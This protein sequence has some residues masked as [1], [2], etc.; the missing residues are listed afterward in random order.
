[1][2]S[3]PLEDPSDPEANKWKNSQGWFEGFKIHVEINQL[4]IPLRAVF[5]TGNKY[6]SPRLKKLLI[7]CQLGDAEYDSKAN[8]KGVKEVG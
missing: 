4:K 2:D 1:V 3:A 6:D 8:D 7:V 5:T